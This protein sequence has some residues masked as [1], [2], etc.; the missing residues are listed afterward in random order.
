MA[1]KNTDGFNPWTLTNKIKSRLIQQQCVREGHRSKLYAIF[2][3]GVRRVPGPGTPAPV[4]L[5]PGLWAPLSVIAA[6]VTRLVSVPGAPA[7]IMGPPVVR[8]HWPGPPVVS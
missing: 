7:I 6:L 1:F 8:G 5:F 2:S 3:P 4:P